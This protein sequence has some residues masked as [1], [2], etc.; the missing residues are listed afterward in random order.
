[1]STRLASMERMNTQKNYLELKNICKSFSTVTVLDNVNF[2]VRKGE[3]HGLIGGNG[4]GKSTLM[5]I[6]GGIY[7]KDSGEICIDGKPV[8]IRDPMDSF[9]SGVA[10]IHQ[11]LMLYSMRTIA[12][13]IY[14]SRLPIKGLFHLIDEDKKNQMAKEWLEIVGLDRPPTALIRD[15]SMAERQLVEIAKAL[16]YESK[17]I[18]FDEST[19]SLTQKESQFLFDVIRRLRDNGTAIIYITHKFQ[20]LFELCDRVSVLRNGKNVG[21]LNVAETNMDEVVSL[22]I[23][24]KL[25]QY[26]PEIQPLEKEEPF[27]EVK[28]FTNRKL[29]NVSFTLNRGEILGI[30]GLVGAGRSELARAIFGIDYLHEGEMYLQGK[31]IDVKNP[32][33]AI[34]HGIGFLTEDRRG[35]GLLLKTSIADNINTL[36]VKDIAIPLMGYILRKEGAKRTRLVFEKFSIMAKNS[37]QRVRFL[38]GGNQQKVVFAKW[39]LADSDVFILDEPTRGVDIK[40]KAEIFEQIAESARRDQS[41]IMISSEEA[42]L[43]G[44]CHRILVM[45][46]GAIIGEFRRGEV[47]DKELIKLVMEGV[48]A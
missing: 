38:S 31:K 33:D 15:L 3:I 10:F 44:V 20:E 35:D 18:I 1:M 36:T 4:A 19:S 25:D 26:Y 45:R 32:K 37:L 40:T 8:V 29:N 48:T 46:D 27:L 14:M 2:S 17:I 7:Q 5:N 23:G 47:T 24:I 16:S 34:K 9:N 13:N 39:F 28:N 22:M 43:I 42:D 41:I 12:D 30:F 11:E 21:T 6:L